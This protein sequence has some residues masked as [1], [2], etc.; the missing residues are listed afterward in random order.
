MAF[1]CWRT[2]SSSSGG[3]HHPAS[4]RLTASK[5]LE[6]EAAACG[7]EVF[8]A[9]V[10]SIPSELPR[11]RPLA[12]GTPLVAVASE[13]VATVANG[14][15]LVAVA[16]CTP[17][18]RLAPAHLL[19]SSGEAQSSWARASHSLAHTSD[20][21]ERHTDSFHAAEAY[22]WP[23]TS[24]CHCASVASPAVACPWRSS[25]TVRW[26]SERLA[27]KR[28]AAKSAAKGPL[29]PGRWLGFTSTSAS[30]P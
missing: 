9:P 4:P 16:A 23:S 19:S 17:T 12:V 3:A 15:K 8:R 6:F 10:D 22:P 2:L 26:P 5:K 24:R 1:P 21:K 13:L 25:G 30:R 29:V 7:G 28:F 18:V 20:R 27:A 11:T 14:R